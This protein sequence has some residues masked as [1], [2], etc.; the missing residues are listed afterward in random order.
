MAES[1]GD[2]LQSAYI[3][4]LSPA[5]ITMTYTCFKSGRIFSYISLE[6]YVPID[7]FSKS[8]LRMPQDL[9]ESDVFRGLDTCLV[10]SAGSVN[11]Y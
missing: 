5:P 7:P 9:I 4:P 6:N 10:H 2:K 3:F 8:P 11:H 1:I